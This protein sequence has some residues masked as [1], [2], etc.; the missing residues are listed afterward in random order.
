MSVAARLRVL[1]VVVVLSVAVIIPTAAYSD[2]AD[3]QLEAES[4]SGLRLRSTSTGV[5]PGSIPAPAEPGAS[6]ASSSNRE[7]VWA[8]VYADCVRRHASPQSSGTSEPS[9]SPSDARD[10]QR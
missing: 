2:T 10:K 1:C 3:C 4:I 8:Q 6:N 5:Y 9:A 7:M